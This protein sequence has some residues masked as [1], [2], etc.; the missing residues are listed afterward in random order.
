[1]PQHAWVMCAQALA[2]CAALPP[3]I[4]PLQENTIIFT[5]S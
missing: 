2:F 1:M 5:Q 4:H 3:L